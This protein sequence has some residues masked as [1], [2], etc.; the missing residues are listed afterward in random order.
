MKV[1]DLVKL[2]FRGNGYPGYGLIMKIVDDE[3]MILWDLSEWGMTR[4]KERELM[5]ISESR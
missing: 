3:Y 1:G 2:K 4:W 5:V